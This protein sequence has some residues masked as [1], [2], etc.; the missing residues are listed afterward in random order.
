MSEYDV[1]IVIKAKAKPSAITAGSSLEMDKIKRWIEDNLCE[2]YLFE[3]LFVSEI[4]E[5]SPKRKVS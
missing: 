1:R 4:M 3:Y 2:S 5:L